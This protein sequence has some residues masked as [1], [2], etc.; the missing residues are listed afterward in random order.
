MDRLVRRAIDRLESRQL[1][2]AVSFWNGGRYD[3]QGGARVSLTL[4]ARRALRALVNP[5]LGALARAYVEQDIDIDGELREVLRVGEQLVDAGSARDATA[6]PLLS[7]VRQTRLG[8]RR[9]IGFHYDVSND[10]FALWLDR[11]RVY[12]SAY[13]RSPDETLERAQEHKLDLVCRKLAL[14]P[15]ERLLDIGCGWG[16][17]IFWA[18]Q[19]Y[20][21]RCLGIT[22]SQRQ[23]DYVAEE[24]ARRGLSERVDVRL[25]DYREL[26][27]AEPFDKIASIGMFEHVGA[28]FLRSYFARIV[29]L[30]KPGGLVLN[31]GIT[32]ANPASTGVRS[33]VSEFIED[34]VF[35]GG[36]LVHLARV[37]EAS[38]AEG[39]ECVDVESLRPHYARTLWHW[40]DRLDANAARAR[41]FVGEKRYR[42]WR[43]Y[44]AGSAHAFARGWITIHQVLAGRPLPDGSL[45]YPYTRGHFCSEPD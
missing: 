15:G 22:L 43:I 7:W 17:L 14:A 36:E 23:H 20:G 16:G 30:L 8:A 13:F 34:Y 28:R 25:T 6:P 24:I 32:A 42:V 27:P 39:L 44:M 35:P 5:S 9:S 4:H 12:S 21:V 31:H 29:E 1:P 3:P 40:V 19:R 33:G 41:E 37:I 2:V 26:P 45:P 38:S 18:A 10:F 11:R